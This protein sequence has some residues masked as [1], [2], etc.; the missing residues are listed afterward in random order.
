MWL[1]INQRNILPGILIGCLIILLHG[2]KTIPTVTPSDAVA[3]TVLFDPATSAQKTPAYD[4]NIL[5]RI[6]IQDEKQSFSGSFRWAH[7]A[8][9]DEILLFTPLGQA[10]AE[11]TRDAEEVRLITSKMEGYYANDVEALTEQILG[12]R[13]PLDGLRY[14]IQGLHSPLT[15]AEKDL[16]RQNQL[17]TIRQDGW[18]IHYNSFTQTSFSTAPLPKN[19]SLFFENQKLKI[20]LIVDNWKVN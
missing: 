4:F 2:C 6:A 3:T 19:I 17:L 16:D 5:G 15:A 18:H 7:F 1:R 11:I 9:N 8:A 13:L 10:V 14:W 12:W 20:R